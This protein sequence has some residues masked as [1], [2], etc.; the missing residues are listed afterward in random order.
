[1]TYVILGQRSAEAEIPAAD[2]GKIPEHSIISKSDVPPAVFDAPEPPTVVTPGEEEKNAEEWRRYRE[3]KERFTLAHADDKPMLKVNLWVP[4]KMVQDAKMD[5]MRLRI[6][7][8]PRGPVMG[9]VKSEDSARAW[10]YSPCFID[11]NIERGRV[12]FLPIAFAGFDMVLY[13][14]GIGESTPQ[15]AE[16]E[17][18]PH[19]VN[20][21]KAGDYTFRMKAAYHHIEAD[22]PPDSKLIS[23]D[24]NPRDALMGL[25]STSD[26]REPKLLAQARQMQATR[27][28]VLAAQEK[29]QA[30]QPAHADAPPAPAADATPTATE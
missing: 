9:A 16:I 3:A 13:K 21:N 2:I 15:E 4:V 26:G 28:K 7:H 24:G 6:F 27:E 12:H 11:P 18:Y 20:R 19:F 25:I 1:M 23:A 29:A 10:L 17:G 30:Q 8:T 5:G 14:T 22:F